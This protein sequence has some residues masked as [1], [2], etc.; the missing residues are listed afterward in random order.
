MVGVDGVDGVDGVPPPGVAPDKGMD[1]NEK[2][3]PEALRDDGS[4][5]ISRGS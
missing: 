1:V 5:G 4:D 3:L 2:S